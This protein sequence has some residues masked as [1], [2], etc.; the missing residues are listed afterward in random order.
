MEFGHRQTYAESRDGF[1]FVEGSAGV[2]QTTAANHGDEEAAGS[3]QRSQHERSL[4][5]DAARG[6]LVNF[7][8][9]KEAEIE[10]FAGMQHGVREGGGFLASHSAQHDGHEP[11]CHLVIGNAAL[12]A[13]IDEVSDFSGG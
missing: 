7:P 8:C 6:V 5:A 2:A 1:K 12:G 4:V 3:D 10:N 13:A 9:G 11:R